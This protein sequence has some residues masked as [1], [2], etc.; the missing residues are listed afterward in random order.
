[1]PLGKGKYDDLCTY[2]RE[3]TKAHSVIVMVFGGDKG[4]GFSVQAHDL[5]VITLPKILRD[6]AQQI[7]DSFKKGQA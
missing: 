2:V 7:E 5:V 1:M 6:T 4:T 3:T